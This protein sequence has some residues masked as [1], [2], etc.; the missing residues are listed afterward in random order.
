MGAW[1]PWL[2]VEVQAVDDGFQNLADDINDAVK[3]AR[4]IGVDDSLLRLAIMPIVNGLAAMPALLHQIGLRVGGGQGQRTL[5]VDP[6]TICIKK[7]SLHPQLRRFR[8][9]L[10]RPGRWFR[11]ERLKRFSRAMFPRRSFSRIRDS[12]SR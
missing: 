12:S 3:K 9:T 8:A 5:N 2:L 11:S 1:P 4:R 6:L 7:S 10:G